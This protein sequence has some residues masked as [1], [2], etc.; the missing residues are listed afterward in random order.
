MFNK[1]CLAQIINIFIYHADL[2]TVG[3]PSKLGEKVVRK[4]SGIGAYSME[5]ESKRNQIRGKFRAVGITR[6]RPLR[7]ENQ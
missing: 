2:P 7:K 6:L 4:D 5:D 3:R 1:K